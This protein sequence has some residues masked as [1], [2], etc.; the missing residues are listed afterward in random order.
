MEYAI[1]HVHIRSS[2]PKG[3]WRGMKSIFAPKH[4]R[5]EMSCQGQ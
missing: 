4:P 5:Q 1:I 2:D 3:R